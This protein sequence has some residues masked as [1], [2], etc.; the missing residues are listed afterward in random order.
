MIG[1]YLK[2]E[3]VRGCEFGGKIV[4]LKCSK[5]VDGKFYVLVSAEDQSQQQSDSKTK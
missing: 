1:L 3:I 4:W 5:T 2:E